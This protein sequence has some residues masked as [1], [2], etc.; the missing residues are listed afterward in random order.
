[1]INLRRSLFIIILLSLVSPT[2]GAGNGVVDP[3][4]AGL[5]PFIEAFGGQN[6]Q[7]AISGTI[8]LP[9]DGK[10]QSVSVQLIHF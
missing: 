2:L 4:A 6:S 9:I 7:F 3:L 5:R 8:L 10:E 1:M